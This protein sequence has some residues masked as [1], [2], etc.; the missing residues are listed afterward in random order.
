M[1]N[2]QCVDGRISESVGNEIRRAET[3]TVPVPRRASDTSY[4]LGSYVLGGVFHLLIEH[5]RI[6]M[7]QQENDGTN[8]VPSHSS[9]LSL[10]FFKISASPRI[11]TLHGSQMISSEDL[12]H[13]SQT[14]RAYCLRRI[15][16]STLAIVLPP[17]RFDA[18]RGQFPQAKVSKIVR[19]FLG[20]NTCSSDFFKARTK[21]PCDPY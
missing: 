19:R 3:S 6:S 12:P 13:T 14:R 21:V 1:Q 20:M 18:R 11:L 4:R 9:P 7:R 8:L 2:S 5:R 15:G 10:C 17:K 16:R